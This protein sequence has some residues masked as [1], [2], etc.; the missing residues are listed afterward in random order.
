MSLSPTGSA[1]ASHDERVTVAIRMRPL[2]SH[3]SVDSYACWAPVSE[4]PDHL[5]QVDE[6][7]TPVPG[8]QPYAYGMC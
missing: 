4:A 1:T 6:A 5:Q 2:N 8:V 3:E 7:A